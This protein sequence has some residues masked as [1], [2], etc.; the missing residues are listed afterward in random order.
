MQM[1]LFL[2]SFSF[3]AKS[4]NSSDGNTT[5]DFG[6]MGLIHHK[7]VVIVAKIVSHL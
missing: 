3:Y 1:F 7:C 5:E 4:L 2:L 6:K